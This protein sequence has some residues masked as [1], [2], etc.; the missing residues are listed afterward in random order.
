M[1]ERKSPEYKKRRA[2]SCF[3]GHSFVY[4]SAYDMFACKPCD[5]WMDHVC[6]CGP[7]P[8][9]LVDAHGAQVGMGPP[10]EFWAA[11][12]EDGKPD[13]PS[14]SPRTWKEFDK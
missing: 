8:Q 11:W 10:C 9:P 1:T 13:R 14:K 6:K 7:E 4:Y 12:V 5:E 2:L 3:R